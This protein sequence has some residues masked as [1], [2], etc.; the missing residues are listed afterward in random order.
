MYKWSTSVTGY[1][2]AIG[3]SITAGTDDMGDPTSGDR[4]PHIHDELIALVRDA[5][6]LPLEA[7][8]AATIQNAR[9]LGIDNAYG[10]VRMP[11][12]SHGLAIMCCL[13]MIYHLIEQIGLGRVADLLVLAKSPLVDI[14]NTQSL[15]YVIKQGVVF[16][17]IS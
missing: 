17:P 3:V 7:L 5:G 2:A 13:G 1:A 8:R 15:S 16:T 6:L 9:Q 14:R 10:T 4:L 11:L 12:L